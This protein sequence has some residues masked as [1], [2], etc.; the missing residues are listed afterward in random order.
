MP[1]SLQQPTIMTDSNSKGHNDLHENEPNPYDAHSCVCIMGLKIRVKYKLSAATMKFHEAVRH[2]TNLLHDSLQIFRIS[3]NTKYGALSIERGT[4][5]GT[6]LA[7]RVFAGTSSKLIS[8]RYVKRNPKLLLHFALQLFVLR[9]Q[10]MAQSEV[11]SYRY[12]RTRAGVNVKPN[13]TGDKAMLCTSCKCTSTLRQIK[14][15]AV[16][17]KNWYESLCLCVHLY[18]L[19]L[20]LSLYHYHYWV[21]RISDIKSWL[22]PP[23]RYSVAICDK[24]KWSWQDRPTLHHSALSAS[25]GWS[26]LSAHIQIYL[27]GTTISKAFMLVLRSICI[28]YNKKLSAYCAR[29]QWKC[30]LSRRRD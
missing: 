16:K 28:H 7:A 19:V 30:K 24:W 8:R 23:S 18:R 10:Q 27:P 22:M 14:M 4:G 2:N 20:V 5:T 17:R 1:H 21:C 11:T 9:K 3:G 26:Q 15:C 25:A 12:L 29:Y 13:H 6:Q